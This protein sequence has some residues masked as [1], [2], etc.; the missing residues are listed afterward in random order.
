MCETMNQQHSAPPFPTVHRKGAA[1]FT[2]ME[3]LVSLSIIV[4]LAALLVPVAGSVRSRMDETACLHNLRGLGSAFQLYAQ[5]NNAT[6]PYARLSE[7]TT[8][9][10]RRGLLPYVALD[11]DTDINKTPFFTCP[12][13]KRIVVERG[14][15]AGLNSFAMNKWLSRTRLSAISRPARTFLASEAK[16]APANNTPTEILD[17]GNQSQNHHR[18]EGGN[19]L[20]Y[21]DFH[22]EFWPDITRLW[23]VPYRVGSSEDMWKP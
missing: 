13:V 9:Y 7:S 17:E 20:L 1:G 15:S 5:D 8:R 19:H 16:I 23:E 18:N 10:W 14:G 6:L 21:A 12:V 3:L 2:L 4:V 11:P 22:V